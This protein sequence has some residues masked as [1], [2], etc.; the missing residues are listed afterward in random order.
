MGAD[1]RTVLVGYTL[2][3]V[4]ENANNRL[5]LRAGNF[6]VH[7][8]E[9]MVDCYSFSQFLNPC[10]NRFVRHAAPSERIS[11]QKKKWARTHRTRTRAF[12]QAV[13]YTERVRVRQLEP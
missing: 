2:R 4:N 7:Q 12:E 1:F 5:V 3:L 9:A 6:C 8:L 11:P 10:C 13:N